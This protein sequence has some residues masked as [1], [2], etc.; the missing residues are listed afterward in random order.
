MWTC[1]FKCST[2]SACIYCLWLC[3]FMGQGE[4]KPFELMKET[5]ECVYSFRLLGYNWNLTEEFFGDLK[6]LCAVYLEREMFLLSMQ[7]VSTSFKRLVNWI[8][9]YHLAKIRN[10]YK[11]QEQTTRLLFSDNVFTSIVML[12]LLKNVEFTNYFLN[13]ATF[14]KFIYIE[15]PCKEH[16]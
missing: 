1:C 14:L 10:D 8:V 6:N 3:C 15:P 5:K 13:G 16:L 2:L 12:P 7:F 9:N 4:I 11:Q